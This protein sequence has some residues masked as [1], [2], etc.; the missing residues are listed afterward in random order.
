MFGAHVPLRMVWRP[1][2]ESQFSGSAV[3]QERTPH[4]PIVTGAVTGGKDL[5]DHFPQHTYLA[6]FVSRIMGTLTAQY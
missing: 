6:Q 2:V 5:I 4:I 1:S 3:R